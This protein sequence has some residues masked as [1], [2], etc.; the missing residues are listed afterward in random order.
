[1]A[2]KYVDHYTEQDNEGNITFTDKELSLTSEGF[3]SLTHDIEELVDKYTG[4]DQIT[5]TNFP[6]AFDEASGQPSDFRHQAASNLLAEALGKGKAGP[7]GYLSGAIGASGL[8]AIKEIGD[9]AVALY[10]NP[11]NYK[12]AFSEFVKDNLSNI[13]GAFA[14]DKTSQELYD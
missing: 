3:I 10:D 7:I 6:G 8:G 9:L 14:K 2:N 5:S 12:D 13:K 11:K 4:I 1:M